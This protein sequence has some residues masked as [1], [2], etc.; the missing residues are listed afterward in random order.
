[1]RFIVAIIFMITVIFGANFYVFYRLWY[2]MPANI[3]GRIILV[4]FA[5][6]AVTSPFLSMLIGDK[7]PM[8]VTSFLYKIGTSW[9]IIMLYLVIIFLL[10]DLIRITHIFPVERFMY[11]S[12]IGLGILTVFMSIIMTLGFVNYKNKNREEVKITINKEIKSAKPLKI[13]VI[14][15]LHLGYGVGKEEFR[16]WVE[17]INNET[18]DVLLIAG[19]AIDNNVNPL[20]DGG[21]AEIFKEIRTKYGVYM[22]LGNHEY[23]S[24][25]SKSMKFLKEA[26]VNL[27]RDSVAIIND[28]FYIVGRDDMSNTNRKTIAELIDSL[29]KSKPIIM[30]D[31]QPYNLEEVEKNGIDLQVSGHTHNGQVLPISWITKLMYEKSHGYLKK[32]NSHIYVSSG[33]GIWGGKFRI[34]TNSE[35]A[36]ILVES[37]K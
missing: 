10:F 25:V 37:E 5:L 4:C 35:Y 7:F 29:D 11:G 33:I 36:V 16:S 32:G 19:D 28:D 34:G 9:I 23:I 3:V 17:L 13:V 12:W 18:P 22:S 21:F 8:P 31:H 1:M 14:S 30:I 15:D 6:L 24:D 26:G 2:M 20:N 27:L